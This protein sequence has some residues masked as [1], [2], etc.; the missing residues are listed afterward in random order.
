M[1]AVTVVARHGPPGAKA[2]GLGYLTTPSRSHTPRNREWRSHERLLTPV[3]T[4]RGSA[5]SGR[6]TPRIRVRDEQ[7]RESPKDKAFL[8]SA[9]K[10][11]R[12]KAEDESNRRSATQDL[13]DDSSSIGAPTSRRLKRV[14]VQTT[15]VPGDPRARSTLVGDTIQPL[16]RTRTLPARPRPTSQ[17]SLESR[18]SDD[19]LQGSSQ[20]NG[21]LPRTILPLG[22]SLFSQSNDLDESMPLAE[23]RNLLKTSCW[24][25]ITLDKEGRTYAGGKYAPFD[26]VFYA[27]TFSRT[28]ANRMME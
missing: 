24:S 21:S 22:E 23:I 11:S 14:S 3:E 20:A 2:F 27:R 28:S 6:S 4:R 25:T 5:N 9:G 26:S 18:D 19:Y 13:L 16:A 1:P 7:R 17:Y 12:V 10:Y 8:I 15:I